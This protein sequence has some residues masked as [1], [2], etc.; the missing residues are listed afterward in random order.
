MDKGLTVPK[1]VLISL[2]KN[3][4]NAPHFICPN[5]LP[6]LSAQAQKF[7]ISMKKASLGVCNPCFLQF[8]LTFFDFETFFAE[9]LYTTT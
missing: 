5:C 6:K 8:E 4:P 3:T 9:N 2:L 7:G 1:L